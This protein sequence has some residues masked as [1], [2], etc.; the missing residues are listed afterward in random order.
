V[1]LHGV[2]LTLNWAFVASVLY[3]CFY[4]AMEVRNASKLT[5]VGLLAVSALGDGFWVGWGGWVG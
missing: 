3:A 2:P 1:S 4:F 5:G